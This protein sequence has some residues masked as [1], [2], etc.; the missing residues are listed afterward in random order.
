MSLSDLLVDT[1]IIGGGAAGAYAAYRLHQLNHT[2]AIVGRG[3]HLGGHTV[4]YR[5]PILT[6]NQP[7]DYGVTWLQ[8]LPVIRDAFAHYNI[9]LV[10]E[11]IDYAIDMFDFATGEPITPLPANETTAALDRYSALL[12]QH[13]Y[14]A[15]GFED[16]PDPV[17]ED[18]V[19]PFSHIMDKYHLDGLL[20]P[21]SS[22]L[23]GLGEWPDYPTLYV[24]KYVGTDYL[25]GRLQLG[26]VRP[27]SH[28]AS[29]IYRAMEQELRQSQTLLFNSS[30][31]RV[32]ARDSTIDRVVV[33]V[34]STVDETRRRIITTTRRRR[35]RAKTLLFAAP[36]LPANLEVLGL[37]ERERA[38]FRQFKDPW[39]YT[40]LIRVDG[41]PDNTFLENHGKDHPFHRPRLPAVLAFRPTDVSKIVRVTVGSTTRGLS[42]PE[43]EDCI[44]AGVDSVRR[45]LGGGNV[46]DPEILVVRDHSPYTLTVSGAAVAAGFYRQLSALQGHRRTYYTGATFDTHH[47]PQVWMVT[48]QV[49]QRHLLPRLRGMKG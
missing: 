30:V 44:R 5:D 10:K 26:W 2:V 19:A 14:L 46:S 7:I 22:W 12:A 16:L 31:V 48:D 34:A 20:D 27:K 33:D 47:M 11:K 45:R 39:F 40:A 23:S 17:P 1:C 38:L 13:P 6:N 28:D 4:T 3:P 36:P 24:M 29:E 49:L 18:L 41:F 9:P 35:I 15:T 42:E 32:D 21:F 43:V 37:D 25:A 8:N